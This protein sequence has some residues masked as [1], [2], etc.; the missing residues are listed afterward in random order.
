MNASEADIYIAFFGW[1]ERLRP[2]WSIKK[3][4]VDFEPA[5]RP[6]IRVTFLATP[7]PHFSGFGNGR[8]TRNHRLVQVDCFYPKG[9][10]RT[11]LLLAQAEGVRA[12]FWPTPRGLSIPAGSS[13]LNIEEEPIVGPLV[14]AGPSHNA[15]SVTVRFST[16]RGP[17]AT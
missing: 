13:T 17:V 6:W 1:L 3:Y 16:E 8:F 12:L 14:E 10:K 7:E 9:E 4:G 2:T 15:V 5:N 11:D